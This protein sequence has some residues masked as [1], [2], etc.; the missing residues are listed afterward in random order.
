VVGSFIPHRYT[1]AFGRELDDVATGVSRDS[2]HGQRRHLR[3]QLLDIDII[4]HALVGSLTGIWPFSIW[5]GHRRQA[6]FA[7]VTGQRDQN[8]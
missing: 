6:V 8:P 7:N 5:T 4:N 3:Y 2:H 1:P